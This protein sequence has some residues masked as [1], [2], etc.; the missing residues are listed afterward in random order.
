MNGF[1][2]LSPHRC[3]RPPPADATPRRT[4]S[5]RLDARRH[6]PPRL[7]PRGRAPRLRRLRRRVLG[8]LRRG[9]RV[10]LGVLRTSRRGRLGRHRDPRGVRGWRPGDHRG[11]GHAGG[12][13]R[14][15][16]GD[17]R[18]LGDPPVDLRHGT[19]PTSRLRSARCR[20]AAPRRIGRSARVLRRDRA[21]CGTDTSSITTRAARDGDDYVVTGAKVWTTKASISELCL[22]LVRTTPREECAR[23]TDGM[24]LLLVDLQGPEVDIRPSRSGPQRGRVVRGALRRAACARLPPHRRGGQGL[25][26]PP[27]RAEPRA[28]PARGRGPRHRAGRDAAS[29]RVRPR[30]RRLRSTDRPEP[31]HRVPARRGPHAVAGRR[32]GDPR[33]VLA[34]RQRL[35]CGEAANTA[36]WLAA[37]AAFFA[38]DRA[39]QTH[40][41]FGYATEYHV[42]R[43]WREARLMKIAPVSQEMV[44]NYI[45]SQVLSLPKSY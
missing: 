11:V 28:H 36:K 34:V 42:E 24:T 17:E 29:D 20:G 23:P 6:R 4:P 44:C 35:A 43:Y 31:G 25:H 30:A 37:E 19:R 45:S 41:G 21:R 2:A 38:A 1:I 3:C 26:V 7:D 14:L 5:G 16:R 10:P 39:V 33:C 27:R 18:L 22:L 13:C 9:S 40:G 8:A 15:R 12:D 32:T